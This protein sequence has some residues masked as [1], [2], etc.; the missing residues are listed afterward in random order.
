M[1]AFF[2]PGPELSTTSRS[3]RPLKSQRERS[4]A[5]TPLT[6]PRRAAPVLGPS[7]EPAQAYALMAHTSAIRPKPRHRSCALVTFG[8][9][10]QRGQQAPGSTFRLARLR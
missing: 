9:L 1:L 5:A 2:A 10:F 8:F 4:S 3:L 7:L 6:S